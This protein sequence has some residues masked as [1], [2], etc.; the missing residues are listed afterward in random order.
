[1]HRSSGIVARRDSIGERKKA[2]LQTLISRARAVEIIAHFIIVGDRFGDSAG[3]GSDYKKP[4]S[5]FLA[6]ADFSER[7]EGEWIEIQGE[8]FVVGI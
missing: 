5:D 6:S 4:A 2:S 3:R 7:A 1:L 8:G